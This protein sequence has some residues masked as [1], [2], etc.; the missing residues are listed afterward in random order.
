M[1]ITLLNCTQEDLEQESNFSNAKKKTPPNSEKNTK[2][3]QNVSPGAARWTMM[4]TR[5]AR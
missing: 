2:K 5:M 4:L 1:M 3:I